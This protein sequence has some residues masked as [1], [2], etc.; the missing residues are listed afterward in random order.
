VAAAL[1]EK[2]LSIRAFMASVLDG[3]GFVRVIVDKP[4]AAKRIFGAHGWRTFEDDVVEVTVPDRPGALGEVADVLG[5]AGVNVQYAYVGTARSARKVNLYLA[6]ADV[7][8]ALA[9]LR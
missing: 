8:A 4:A 6:V 7:K 1:G 5:A 2:G 9:A 3:R